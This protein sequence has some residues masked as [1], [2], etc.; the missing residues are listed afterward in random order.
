MPWPLRPRPTFIPEQAAA[1][2]EAGKHVDIAKPPRRDVPGCQ[3]IAERA[4]KPQ[5]RSS[6]SRWISRD[7]GHAGLPG[8]GVRIH[9]GEIGK[10]VTVYAEYQTS[11]MFQERDN[12]VRQA[13]GNPEV[14]L[15]AWGIDRTRPVNV[16]PSRTSMPST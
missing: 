3:S 14:K 11:L 2:V 13:P 9:K 1:A 10:L 16:S 12:Q 6:P 15:R 7:P 4:A 5:R 8:G